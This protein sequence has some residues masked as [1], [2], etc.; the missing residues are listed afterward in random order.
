VHGADC[1]EH[2]SFIIA[3]ARG[4]CIPVWTL[5][6]LLLE[7]LRFLSDAGTTHFAKAALIARLPGCQAP[8]IRREL[9]RTPPVTLDT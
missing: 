2:A 1:T 3:H 9:I 6:G 8:W 5:K 4:L 7:H